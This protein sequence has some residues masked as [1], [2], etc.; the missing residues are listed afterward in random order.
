MI[1]EPVL[2]G[3]VEDALLGVILN[4]K[5]EAVVILRRDPGA[6]AARRAA[7]A[8]LAHRAAQLDTSSFAPREVGVTLARLIKRI[9][10]ELD[11]YLL[12]DREVEKLAGDPAASMIRRVF[13]E[14]EEL[15]E[16]HLNVLEGVAD[17]FSTPHF[18]NLKKYAARPDRHVPRAADCAR[19]VDHEVELDPRHGRVLRAEPVPR[20]NL[21]HHRRP[22]QHARADRQHQGRAGEIRPRGRARTMCSSSPMAPRPPTR[23]STRR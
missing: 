3:S 13:Y 16:V 18:D 4:G 8:R 9:R 23:W 1:Y 11:I 15:M 17:R 20:G 12:T 19:Q 10:P 14:V 22:R 2:V 7:A 5:I 21:G 6:L